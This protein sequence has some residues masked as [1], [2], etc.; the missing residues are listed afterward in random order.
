MNEVVIYTQHEEGFALQSM[1]S[2]SVSRLYLQVD[3]DDKAENWPDERIWDALDRRIGAKQNRGPV[4]QKGV[5]PMRSYV[6]EPMTHGRLFLVG[7]AAHIV[8][9]TGAKGLNL[10][11]ADVSMLA[12]AFIRHYRHDDETELNTYAER[13]LRR[14]WKVERFSWFCTRLLHTDFR[15]S[16]FERRLQEADLDYLLS[17]D[18]AKASFAENYAGLPL[19]CVPDI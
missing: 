19:D 2:P 3:N 18:S 17:S 14:V 15:Q 7:D 8:P 13:V 10:A 12:S 11:V 4:T 9:P 6:S 16:A 5:T 1:R